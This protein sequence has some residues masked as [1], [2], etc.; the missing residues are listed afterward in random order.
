MRKRLICILAM[1]W[2]FSVCL[3][4]LLLFTGRVAVNDDLYYELQMDAGILNSAG[5]SE[6]ALKS[7]DRSLSQYLKGSTLA[8]QN[9]WGEIYS[10]KVFGTLQPVF[11]ERE[12]THLED[13]QKLIHLLT[14]VLDG[15]KFACGLLNAAM[16]L[17]F[18]LTPKPKRPTWKQMVFSAAAAVMMFLLAIG[19]FA[20]W[21]A[22][23]FDGAFTFF[24]QLL[25]T[26][27]LW[28]LDPGTDLLIRI[29]PSSMFAQMGLQIAKKTFL[30]WALSLALVFLRFRVWF[31]WSGKYEEYMK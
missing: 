13:C 18:W 3:Y 17:M 30:M 4:W 24:H 28:L 16:F 20:L 29:C 5:I 22:F 23:D 31:L 12:M 14:E 9:D 26:N 27:D 2:M 19:G 7:L 11:N 25:F 15:S 21:A 8:F 1:L 6:D 10:L